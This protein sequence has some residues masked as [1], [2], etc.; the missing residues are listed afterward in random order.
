MKTNKIHFISGLFI[1]LFVGVHLFNHGYSIL[2]PEKHIELM[3]SLRKLYRN[4]FVETLLLL[5][6]LTQIYSGFKLL[7]THWKTAGS[8]FEKLHVYTGLYLAI[9]LIIHLSAVLAGRFILKLD[10][11]FYFGVAGLN[12]FP[13]N[14]FFVPYY[15]L[16]ILSFFGH[17]AAIHNKKMKYSLL[18]ITP[19]MESIFI[20]ILGIGLCLFIFT[21][22]TNRFRG[23]EIPSEYDVLIGK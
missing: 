3:L 9:F 11:N 17:L 16:A 4:I 8:F 12:H 14:L 15:A 20:L 5:A 7:K 6:V 19:W 18:G 10:T 23:Y 22:L 1:S 2:G 13:T 21:G